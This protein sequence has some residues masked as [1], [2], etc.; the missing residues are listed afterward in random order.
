M[1][2]TDRSFRFDL[3]PAGSGSYGFTMG[4]PSGNVTLSMTITN[5]LHRMDATVRINPDRAR[6]IAN[7]LYEAA[8]YAENVI[9]ETGLGE[10]VVDAP[11]SEVQ[12]QARAQTDP[13]W[14]AQLIRDATEGT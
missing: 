11:A 5:G 2:A 4:H 10:S 3:G 6:A 12:R 14:A 9:A 8:D 1:P 7:A 13:A